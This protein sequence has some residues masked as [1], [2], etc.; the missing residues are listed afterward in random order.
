MIHL[1]F[2][3]IFLLFVML[4]KWI[5]SPSMIGVILKI[6]GYTYGPLLG[7]FSFGILTKRKVNDRVVPYIAIAGPLVCFFFDAYQK[8]L[9]GPF[10]IGLELIIING[11][12]V[13]LGLWVFSKP[14]TGS[15]WSEDADKTEGPA[16]E[17]EKR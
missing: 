12:L 3:F 9:F 8:E 16:F 17:L 15:V 6:A 7:L 2:A 11:L 4:F 10:R 5:N 1:I 13:F 14:Q